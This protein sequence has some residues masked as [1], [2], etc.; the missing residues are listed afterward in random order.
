MKSRPL[1]IG[2]I[3]DLIHIP[4]AKQLTQCRRGVSSR[5]TY[6]TSTELSMPKG[7]DWDL[8]LQNS[9]N[10]T[11]RIRFLVKYFK[12][13]SVRSKLKISLTVT[14]EENTWL[15]TKTKIKKLQ[16]C[17]YH[18]ADTRLILHARQSTAPVIIR[19]TDTDALI[20]LSY[21]CNGCKPLHTG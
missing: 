19:A 6:I 5:R 1:Q 16:S 4:T 18:E 21:G 14:E 12:T 10:K 11:E 7:K 15:I 3:F 9:E 8:F 13:D 2:I 17:N 20:L